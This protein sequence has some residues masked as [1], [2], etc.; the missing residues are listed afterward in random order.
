MQNLYKTIGGNLPHPR[1]TQAASIRQSIPI[2][3]SPK[4][5]LDPNSASANP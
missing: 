1:N 4:R 5:D 2:Q 3:G